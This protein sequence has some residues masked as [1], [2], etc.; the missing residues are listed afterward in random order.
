LGL[1]VFQGLGSLSVAFRQTMQEHATFTGSG[2]LQYPGSVAF[3]T[4]PATLPGA[5]ALQG[6]SALA[7]RAI[8]G[9]SGTG[10]A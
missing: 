3:Q 6:T 8:A 7:L 1:I 10:G 4:N 2:G 9:F 5:G